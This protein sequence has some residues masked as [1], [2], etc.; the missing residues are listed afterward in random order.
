MVRKMFD[1]IICPLYKWLHDNEVGITIG[2]SSLVTHLSV[3]PVTADEVLKFQTALTQEITR[4]YRLKASNQTIDQKSVL[5][6]FVNW[7]LEQR[8]ADDFNKFLTSCFTATQPNVSW[9]AAVLA[10]CQTTHKHS[11]KSEVL[12][13]LW[14]QQDKNKA[15]KYYEDELQLT[16]LEQEN[17]SAIQLLVN[18]YL[19]QFNLLEEETNPASIIPLIN[20]FDF[21]YIAAAVL[22]LME[23]SIDPNIL[24]SSGLLDKFFIY[25]A[26]QL[27][28][29]HHLY[30]FLQA[31]Q[32]TPTLMQQ[33][34]TLTQLI[35][36]ESIPQK[37]S[38][39]RG[40]TQYTL[41]GQ[42]QHNPQSESSS[43]D[44]GR[45]HI[46][47]TQT[48]RTPI[49]IIPSNYSAKL[50]ISLFGIEH[51]RCFL[52][53]L[54]QHPENLAL[55]QLLTDALNPHNQEDIPCVGQLLSHVNNHSDKTRLLNK[56]ATLCTPETI[57]RLIAAKQVSAFFLI[58]Y[59]QSLWD[60]L[61][62]DT[63][64]S[65]LS[66][67]N[68][69]EICDETEILYKMLSYFLQHN[70]FDES[71][72]IFS[73][74]L[75]LMTTNSWIQED[76]LLHL[77]V[78]RGIDGY[79]EH[80]VKRMN[81]EITNAIDNMQ[82]LNEESILNV[83]D[84]WGSI[85][86]AV[87]VLKAI[88]AN[89]PF[90]YNDKYALY[91]EITKKFVQTADFNLAKT[92]QLLCPD[93]LPE[94]KKAVSE[95]ECTLITII[96]AIDHATLRTHAIAMLENVPFAR[97]N[98][99]DKVYNGK[100]ILFIAIEYH[101]LGLIKELLHHPY[102]R[103]VI[104]DALRAAANNGKWDIVQTIL[105]MHGDNKPTQKGVSNVL[106]EAVSA[107]QWDIVQTILAM[108]DDNK[109]HQEEVRNALS[110]AAS[111]GQ[112]AIVQTIL[113]MRADN[114]PTQQG[115]SNVLWTAARASKWD[116]VQTI[117]A[118][119]DD[120]KPNQQGVHNVL[121]EAVSA[122]QWDI[123]QTILAMHGDNKPTQQGVNNVLWAAIRTRQWDIVQTILAMSDDNKPNQQGVHNALS[124]AASAGQLAIVQTII[125]M[126]GDNKPNQKGVS[127]ALEQAAF[128]GESAIVQTIIAMH[129]DNKPNQQ[130]VSYALSTAARAGKLDIVQT[131]LAM[132]ADN[133]PNQEGV[134][135][136]LS[137]AA[138]A[139][140]LA[141]VQT[142]LAMRADNKLS[143][144]KVSSIFRDAVCNKCWDLVH[145]ILLEEADPV[146][147]KNLIGKMKT[148]FQKTFSLPALQKEQIVALFQSAQ[149]GVLVVSAYSSMESKS[150][151]AHLRVLLP[152]MINQALLLTN[153]EGKGL[154]QVLC[155][156]DSI[157]SQSARP[158]NPAALLYELYAQHPYDND[159]RLV[160]QVCLASLAEYA[161]HPEAW[162]ALAL[163]A[164]NEKSQI[165]ATANPMLYHALDNKI[166]RYLERM[167]KNSRK[168]T[169]SFWI[170]SSF[171]SE[172]A[173]NKNYC[174]A[175]LAG[176]PELIQDDPRD[177]KEFILCYKHKIL[178]LYDLEPR[179]LPSLQ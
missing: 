55:Q 69:L 137:T 145:I 131:I 120:N 16:W 177:I 23:R 101:N 4:C 51:W 139:G 12:F 28:N 32:T 29:I 75:F 15:I 172:A 125:A 176:S 82:V 92:L 70:R 167:E 111:A 39:F 57:K 98:W 52:D 58:P 85:L 64:N 166:H 14:L 164:Y 86:S 1:E 22:W 9:F 13:H 109:P 149:S 106:W 31:Y 48:P 179:L 153:E 91:A 161:N 105:A 20:Q 142:I 56:I 157:L 38:Q 130:G 156:H 45:Q 40:Y 42:I 62:L 24:I 95:K 126:R 138:S 113:A 80:R 35:R 81:Q 134:H 147:K 74:L 112:L 6:P 121:W 61:S 7:L 84:Y 108:H 159:Y 53:N 150:L 89:V 2:V 36:K 123:V 18:Y 160:A 141:I 88:D 3:T 67:L 132:S 117:L 68:Q 114:K 37:N 76:L 152:K 71:E 119:H 174:N 163:I 26:D 133:Q 107:R 103:P 178:Q 173:K 165:T 127:Y 128:Y 49:T 43:T 97:L 168:H 25:N 90:A 140:Q 72:I 65:Y 135:H 11:A 21:E 100:T 19:Q 99:Q 10:Y 102:T 5:T 77:R 8:L 63:L 122:R 79:L 171:L 30:R 41:S 151:W 94:N 54:L 33:I 129:G 143:R 66:D 104:T 116:I 78:L 155:E 44:D 47:F 169:L 136:A 170:Q 124:I 175:L 93:P 146:I 144:K 50:Y 17:W 115:V 158:I 87:N 73:R 27:E 162:M 118:M 96:A 148:D 83:K 60:Q 46:E 110:T 34:Q 154:I 59:K